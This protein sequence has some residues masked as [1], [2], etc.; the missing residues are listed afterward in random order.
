MAN[1]VRGT[2]E[3][4][5][6]MQEEDAKLV[7][8]KFTCH[9]PKGGSVTFP[10]RKYRDEVTK[11]YTLE[12]GNVYTIPLGVARHLNNCGREI[13]AHLLDAE[14]KPMI[15]VGKKEYRFSFQSLDYI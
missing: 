8:G 11:K 13:S 10:Y 12:D 9:D 6:Q 5:K 4:M 1:V 3:K 2:S 14:G 15:G 7:K